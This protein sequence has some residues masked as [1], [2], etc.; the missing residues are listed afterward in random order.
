MVIPPIM[1]SPSREGNNA[2]SYFTEGYVWQVGLV[3]EIGGLDQLE[4]RLKGPPPRSSPAAPRSGISP[5]TSGRR[6]PASTGRRPHIRPALVPDGRR[7]GSG[8][9]ASWP[10]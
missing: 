4:G 6:A 1:G 2:L 9:P 10:G 8:P 5:A 3:P 7:P